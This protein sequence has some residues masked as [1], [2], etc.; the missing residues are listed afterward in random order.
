MVW[1]RSN[2]DTLELPID[3]LALLILRDYESAGG[4]NWQNWMREAEQQGSARDPAI[5]AAL[6]EGW[7]WLITHGLVV[8]NSSQSTSDSVQVSR[9]GRDALKNGIE[10]LA[11]GERLGMSLHPRLAQRVQRQFLLGEFELAVFGLQ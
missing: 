7:S 6:S 1:T 5:N 3:A 8:R 9:L 11:A 2:A 4:W 10:R